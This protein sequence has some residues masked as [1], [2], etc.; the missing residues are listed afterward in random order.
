MT[1]FDEIAFNMRSKTGEVACLVYR[2][3]RKQKIN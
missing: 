3:E 2:T 1:P